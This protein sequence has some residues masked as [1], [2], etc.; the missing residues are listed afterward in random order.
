MG[1]LVLGTSTGL[2]S[3]LEFSCGSRPT[4]GRD[5]DKKKSGRDR[6]WVAIQKKILSRPSTGRDPDKKSG[7]DLVLL[8][9]SSRENFLY[10]LFIILIGLY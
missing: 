6:P 3:R 5:P 1:K 7:R 4:T 9:Q 8:S 10:F 2:K